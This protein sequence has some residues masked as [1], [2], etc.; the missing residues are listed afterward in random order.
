[1]H[2]VTL[3]FMSVGILCLLAS[4]CA[5]VAPQYTT[6]AA[7]ADA[8]KQATSGA[9]S[10]IAL[11][12]FTADK[13]ISKSIMCRG[14]GPVSPPGDIP[15]EQF[16]RNALLQELKTAQVLDDSSG[17]KLSAVLNHIDFSSAMSGG[18]WE[19]KMTFSSP[20]TES[21]EVEVNYPFESS[22]IAYTACQQVADALPAATQ[23]LV[24]KLVE[25]PSFKKAIGSAM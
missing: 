13:G 10:K 22:F 24:I 20:T 6:S 9:T 12:E 16:I 11:G 19:I 21:F 1:M 23:Q 2:S 17:S 14:E 18:H 8:I 3:R 5:H 4:A 25:H 7:N 15:F